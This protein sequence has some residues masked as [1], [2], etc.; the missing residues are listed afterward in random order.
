[1]AFHLAKKIGGNLNHKCFEYIEEENWIISVSGTVIN[2]HHLE[3]GGLIKRYEYHNTPLINIALFLDA[4]GNKELFS[5]DESGLVKCVNLKTDS[6]VFS[7]NL[8]ENIIYGFISKSYKKI[9]FKTN[10]LDLQKNC[11]KTF[12]FFDNEIQT[13][14]QDSE[15]QELK[16]LYTKYCGFKQSYDENYAIEFQGKLLTFYDLKQNKIISKILHENEVTVVEINHENNIVAVGDLIG[17]IYLYYNPLKSNEIPAKFSK[18]HWHSKPLLSLKFNKISNILISGGY[19]VYSYFILYLK[20]FK[21]KFWFYGITMN[22]RRISA[23]DFP[24]LLKIFS[25]IKTKHFIF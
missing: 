10:S 9:Y 3:T 12:N 19:E 2:I 17:K 20:Y 22:L 25:V 1:M 21:R 13:I 15:I 16:G 24:H 11:L 18:F 23:Q 7:F 4:K 5:F 8:K 6:I 14:K